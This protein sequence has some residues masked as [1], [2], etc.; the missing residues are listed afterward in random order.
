M[1][2]IWY[3]YIAVANVY[4]IVIKT[5]FNSIVDPLFSI[6]P[7]KIVER[8]NMNASITCSYPSGAVIDWGVRRNGDFSFIQPDNSTNIKVSAD[9][10]T[11]LF[12]PI[13]SGDAGEYYCWIAL[14]ATDGI[15][16]ETVRL[17]ILSKLLAI[18]MASNSISLL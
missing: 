7:D 17:T 12:S 16:S 2:C 8:V 18:L 11:L 3:S 6:T 5:Y 14:S 1:H 10:R 4:S 13:M 9:R 15:Y